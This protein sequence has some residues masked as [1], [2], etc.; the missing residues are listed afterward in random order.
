[1]AN[2]KSIS[3]RIDLQRNFIVIIIILLSVNAINTG[4]HNNVSARYKHILFGN[5]WI[6]SNALISLSLVLVPSASSVNEMR[7]WLLFCNAENVIIWHCSLYF[8]FLIWLRWSMWFSPFPFSH[9]LHFSISF[10]CPLKT[11]FPHLMAVI[12]LRLLL[13]PFRVC[14]F[15]F[16]FFWCNTPQKFRLAYGK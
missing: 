3:K 2:G 7:K 10:L 11:V 1:M 14:L 13:I 5:H 4:S 6:E 12:P 8:H 16:F 15:F 9:T